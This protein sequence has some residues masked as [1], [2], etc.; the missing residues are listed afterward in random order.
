[1]VKHR[2]QFQQ[3][4]LYNMASLASTI[5]E[6][7]QRVQEASSAA[8][9]LKPSAR[10]CKSAEA[11]KSATRHLRMFAPS[12]QSRRTWPDPRHSSTVATLA[13][14]ATDS[15]KCKIQAA[16]D[17]H[18][19]MMTTTPSQMHTVSGQQP[20]EVH[21]RKTRQGQQITSMADP[22]TLTF[23]CD[24]CFLLHLVD[25]TSLQSQRSND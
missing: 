20:T 12:P 19:W 25:D 18:H 5:R 16:M 21:L 7:L 13:T 10:S 22:S 4:N 1:M 3:H 9:R 17:T 23:A 24:D 2:A 14:Q 8:T 6:Q 15:T 11:C